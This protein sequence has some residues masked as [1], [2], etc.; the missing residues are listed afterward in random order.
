LL[1][2]TTQNPSWGK[3]YIVPSPG[4]V[5]PFGT[6]GQFN[7]PFDLAIDSLHRV[8]V[9]D[10]GSSRIQ[11][12]DVSGNSLQQWGGAGSGDGQ[13]GVGGPQGVAV[14]DSGF[15][16]VADTGNSRIQIFTR[17]GRYVTQWGS[18]GSGIGQF[19]HPAGVAVDRDGNILVADT[20]NNRIQRFHLRRPVLAVPLAETPLSLRLRVSPNPS[21]GPAVTFALPRASGVQLGVFDISGR[22]VRELAKGDFAAGE[23]T[24]TWDGSDASGQM[25]HAGMYFVRLSGPAGLRTASVLLL[26]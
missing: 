8:Y 1:I 2:A 14:D 25:C 16:Y 6:P 20:Q 9:A 17:G 26:R 23:H 21:T 5:G 15:V 19:N 11:V 22:L 13:F 24:L 12:T 10:A 4:P 3:Q 18:L 7:L